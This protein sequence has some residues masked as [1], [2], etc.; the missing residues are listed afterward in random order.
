MRDKNVKIKI[1]IRMMKNATIIIKMVV[2]KMTLI[3]III[4]GEIITIKTMKTT[5]E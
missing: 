5:M 3:K 2:I 4:I 1:I